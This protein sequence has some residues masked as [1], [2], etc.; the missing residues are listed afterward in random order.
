MG[1]DDGAGSHRRQGIHSGILDYTYILYSV[2]NISNHFCSIVLNTYYGYYGYSDGNN[3]TKDLS[4]KF[5]EHN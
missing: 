4:T 5:Y 1:E 3:I 2:R